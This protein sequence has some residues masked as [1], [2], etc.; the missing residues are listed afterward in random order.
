MRSLVSILLLP[1]V[2]IA[3]CSASVET[4]TIVVAID[5]DL[6]A[7]ELGVRTRID[8]YTDS[9]TWFDTRDI[10]TSKEGSF[11]L[12]FGIKKGSVVRARVRVYPA[13]YTRAYEGERY[14]DWPA[15]LS[16]APT[17]V[18]NKSPRLVASGTDNTPESEPLPALAIDKLVRIDTA[19]A[20]A[21]AIHMHGACAGTMA[22]LTT[23]E[24]CDATARARVKLGAPKPGGDGKLKVLRD[25]CD[26]AESSESVACIPGGVFVLGDHRSE[27]DYPP[28]EFL[29]VTT[30]R[31]AH[32]PKF[33]MDRQEITVG[34]YRAAL[35]KGFKPKAV[36]PAE[37]EGPFKATPTKP[38]AC[39]YSATPRGREDYALSCASFSTFRAICQFEGGDLPTEAQW[40]YVARAAG[41]GGSRPFPWGSQDLPCDKLLFGR[42]LD[43]GCEKEPWPLELAVRDANG[44]PTYD[45]DRTPLGV[46]GLG[47][48]LLEFV[49]DSVA[50][51]TDPC[52][53]D[54][55]WDDLTCTGPFP[56]PGA[57]D[58]SIKR[59]GRGGSWISP[60]NFT[61]AAGR[62]RV[63]LAS[64]FYGARCVYPT[65]P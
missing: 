54:A 7:P 17:P 41:G 28:D 34:R 21:T 26:P 61:R 50:E 15:V 42:A 25:A 20:T 4:D 45:G 27:I 6:P 18:A 46:Y 35:A 22:N 47:G 14:A 13:G 65:R 5:T 32:L 58:G 11:P 31:L 1:L 44:A 10:D 63:G 29:Q 3:S 37:N 48:S 8:L 33:W 16:E 51:Y 56:D 23:W 43:F 49:R 53:T 24:S 30:E 39:T 55:P 9:G 60:Y 19:T 59:V 57:T 62:V 40:E 2:T 38:T 64:T 12:T 36:A 52:W